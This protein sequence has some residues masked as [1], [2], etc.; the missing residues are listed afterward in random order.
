MTT[1]DT[2]PRTRIRINWKQP[3]L[4][5]MDTLEA[6]TA[7]PGKATQLFIGIW[8]LA[9]IRQSPTVP[10]SRQTMARVGVSRFCATDALRRLEEAGL[11]KVWRLPGRSPRV[12]LV[13]PGTGI[14]LDM[15]PRA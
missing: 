4:I 1:R 10:L 5:R 7:V 14:P 15:A 3:R 13:E 9:T 6:A 2:T 11:I 8:M 12:T